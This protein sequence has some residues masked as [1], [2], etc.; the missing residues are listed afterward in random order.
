MYLGTK[1]T[2]GHFL[3]AVFHWENEDVRQFSLKVQRSEKRFLVI[4]VVCP[5][6]CHHFLVLQASHTKPLFFSTMCK[7]TSETNVIL[8]STGL[9]RTHIPKWPHYYH[10]FSSLLMT[11]PFPFNF[12]MITKCMVRGS[13]NSKT[14]GNTVN[15]TL[16]NPAKSILSNLTP[17]TII[18]TTT[19]KPVPFSP[20]LPSFPVAA[21]ALQGMDTAPTLANSELSDSG[22]SMD[23]AGSS[24]SSSSGSTSGGVSAFT[25]KGG[26]AVKQL[27]GGA[28]SRMVTLMETDDEGIQ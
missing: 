21:S 11:L 27:G 20:F 3:V 4:Q 25:R 26:V 10:Y 17:T 15:V 16:A 18:T 9:I 13:G 22:S 24:S 6:N 19:C 23:D 8:R 12:Q 14:N 7:A 5:A 28:N 2:T 1:K